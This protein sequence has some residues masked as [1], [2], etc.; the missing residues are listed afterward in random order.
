[1]IRKLIHLLLIAMILT[2]SSVCR[3]GLC[4]FGC[5]SSVDQS[6]VDVASAGTPHCCEE[7]A[8]EHSDSRPGTPSDRECP[9]RN[10]TGSCNCLCGG[11]VV[12]EPY[13]DGHV[14]ALLSSPLDVVAVAGDSTL[15]G[16]RIREATPQRGP[17]SHGRMLCIRHESFL[18]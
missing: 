11:A 16:Q 1:M 14:R 9:S 13:E 5:C 17:V 10:G 7:K 18:L 8:K 12:V 6:C 2:C 4:G 3:V 15:F